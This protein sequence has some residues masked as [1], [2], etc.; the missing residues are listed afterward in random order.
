MVLLW[1]G[2][3]NSE[4]GLQEGV[5]IQSPQHRKDI[6]KN[7]QEHFCSNLDERFK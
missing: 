7:K 4:E 1:I 2:Q 6:P 5:P 3:D